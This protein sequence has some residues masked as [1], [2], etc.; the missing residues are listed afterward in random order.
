ML[1]LSGWLCAG[2]LCAQQ[3]PADWLKSARAGDTS[4]ILKVAEAYLLG[5]EG[6]FRPDSAGIWLKPLAEKAA[7]PEAAYLYGNLLLRGAPRV[8]R[9][10]PAGIRLLEKSAQQGNISAIQVLSDV[11]RGKDLNPAFP[12][13]VLASS[14]NYVALFKTVNRGAELNDAQSACWLGVCY[15]EG[16][17]TTRNDSLAIRYIASSARRQFPLGQMLLADA[18]L[19]GNYRC[20]PDLDSARW[21]Y[22]R[23]QQNP[24]ATLE[25]QSAGLEG[26]LL[27]DRV[28]NQVWNTIWYTTGFWEDWLYELQVWKVRKEDRIVKRY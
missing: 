1:C 13:P 5:I 3:V 22:T 28:Y 14:K 12:D 9:D 16:W 8:S 15:A 21:Y 11:Y 6:P 2:M 25:E 7:H 26:N 19:R 4:A 17:G 20:T 10:I 24:K 18:Y 27:C 23:L